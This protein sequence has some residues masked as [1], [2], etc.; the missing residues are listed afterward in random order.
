MIVVRGV[1]EH[2]GERGLHLADAV[3]GVTVA[4]PR[5]EEGLDLPA[6]DLA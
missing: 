1:G 6:L 3:L 4:A 5:G 2:D